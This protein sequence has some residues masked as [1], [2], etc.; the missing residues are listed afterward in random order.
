M[1]RRSIDWDWRNDA[2]NLLVEHGW[3][4]EY[5]PIG[6]Y[7]RIYV[8]QNIPTQNIMIKTNELESGM[9]HIFNY[10][11]TVEYVFIP[12]IFIKKYLDIIDI[13]Y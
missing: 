10:V 11:T 7:A 3:K 6:D 2:Y 4:Q 8:N 1:F 13:Y 12:A 9:W 5:R